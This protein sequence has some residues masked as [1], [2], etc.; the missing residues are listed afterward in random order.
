VFVACAALVGLAALL[1][2]GAAASGAFD[3]DHAVAVSPRL[4]P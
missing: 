1:I 4:S 2:A 3:A